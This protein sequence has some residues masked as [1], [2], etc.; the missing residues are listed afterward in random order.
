MDNIG[1]QDERCKEENELHHPWKY[2]KVKGKNY[3]NIKQ[4][5][6]PKNIRRGGR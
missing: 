6:F 1:S 2:K 3:L 4:N 5:K